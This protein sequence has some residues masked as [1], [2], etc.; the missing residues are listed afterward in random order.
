MR[1]L[2]AIRYD[3]LFQFR[4]GFYFVYLLITILYIIVILF[5]PADIQNKATTFLLFSDT[6]TLGF[7]FIGAI[8]LLE[9][10]QNI[11][12]SLFVTPL[13]IYEYF[14]AKV[15]SLAIISMIS[16]V[17]I[18]IFTHGLSANWHVF[19]PGFLLSSGFFTIF[20]AI[21]GII[22]KSVNDYFAKILGIGLVMATPILSYF[23]IFETPVFYLLPTHATLILID[24]VFVN[25]SALEIFYAF[26]NLSFWIAA[27]S[28][29]AS[30]V[31]AKHIILR[32]GGV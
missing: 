13:K 25:Y 7:F 21:F 14:L 31:F 17:A 11:L 27:A 18:L 5:L 26:V 4:H 29:L 32:T 15:I 8:I 3:M 24:V 20:G 12:E 23:S 28:G 1:L 22:A 30:W 6:A 16:A 10:D 19:I 2:D 9:K